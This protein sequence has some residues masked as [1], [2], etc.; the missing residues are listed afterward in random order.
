MVFDKGIPEYYTL[1][2]S[3]D[4]DFHNLAGN[5]AVSWTQTVDLIVKS[6][7]RLKFDI[8]KSIGDYAIGKIFNCPL[9]GLFYSKRKMEKGSYTA[10]DHRFIGKRISKKH[11]IEFKIYNIE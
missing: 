10:A 6:N 8:E 3:Y 7:S 9:N 4:I 11:F 2:E 1:V 5:H